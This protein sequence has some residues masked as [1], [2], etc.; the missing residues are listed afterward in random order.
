MKKKK[1]MVHDFM[2]MKQEGKKI[3][4]I[5]SYDYPTAKFAEAADMD[6]ILVGD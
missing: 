5:T 2:R 1:M 6:M 4:W 3:T